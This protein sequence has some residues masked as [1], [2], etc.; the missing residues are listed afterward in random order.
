MKSGLALC[1]IGL[2]PSTMGFSETIPSNQSSGPSRAFSMAYNKIFPTIAG[3]ATVAAAMAGTKACSTIKIASTTDEST[4]G[5]A[6]YI[7]YVMCVLIH[8]AKLTSASS[9][10]VTLADGT[11]LHSEI[12]SGTTIAA[13]S[14][15]GTT[16]GYEARIWT[17]SS[18]CTVT[19][20]FKPLLYMIFDVK[21]TGT[22]LTTNKGEL[23]I[24]TGAILGTAGSLGFYSVYDL[25]ETGDQSIELKG[26]K[27]TIFSDGTSEAF[28]GKLTKT[29]VGTSSENT[30]ASFA[31]SNPTTGFAT[32]AALNF[33]GRYGTDTLT[34]GLYADTTRGTVSTTTAMSSLDVSGYSCFSGA[35]GA[36]DYT[37]TTTTGCSALPVIT[38][39]E[40]LAAVATF[41]YDTIMATTPVWAVMKTGPSAL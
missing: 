10:T 40:T 29:S 15:F 35:L 13:N 1:L 20:S 6:S 11:V 17:C 33:T 37:I 18:S 2:F 27:T 25:P 28:H 3:K 39:S 16:Y 22:S 7:N 32:V 5:F 26:M 9:S 12:A 23:W 30:K 31:I 24:D 34:G 8:D 41:T 14:A 21:V 19:T 38:M 36:S 4:L